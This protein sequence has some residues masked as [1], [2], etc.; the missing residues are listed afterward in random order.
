MNDDTPVLEARGLVKRF[1]V[2]RT[3]FGR[4][5]RAVSAVDEVDLQVAAGETLGLIGESGS[6]KSTAGRLVARLAKPDAGRVALL[7]REVGDTAADLRWF[8]TRVQVVLQ[9]PFSSLDPT[10][11]VGH[12]VAEPLVVHKRG[13]R[14]QREEVAERML[15]R[16][17]LGASYAWR[18]PAELSGGQRQRVA[19]ARGL[20]LEPRL[21]VADEPTSA[22]DLSTRS[23][24][25]NLLLELQESTGIACLLIS[26]DFATIGHLAHRIAVLYLGKVVEEGPAELLAENPA[27]P[28]TK[29]MM[30][31]VPVPDPSSQN[32]R[33]R[34]A[35]SGEIPSPIDLPSG[36][37]FSSRCPYAT[38]HCRSVEPEMIDLSGG[39]RVACHLYDPSTDVDWHTAPTAS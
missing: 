9:D 36:C 35:L 33:K 28:Y 10:K 22:L 30:S 2:R 3:L 16:V 1:P 4:V 37:R 38:D 32:K 12:A 23:E 19:I 24:I 39:H 29:A 15:D 34:I 6:G 31:A 26:H 7:G 13:N 27:H 18:Y 8:R 20:V 25:L 11:T 5:T 17:G 21:L 14:S